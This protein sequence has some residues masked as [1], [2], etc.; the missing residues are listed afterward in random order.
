MGTENQISALAELG[1]V[2]PDRVGVAHA[3]GCAHQAGAA[4]RAWRQVVSA[5]FS[6]QAL[7][8]GWMLCGK[9]LTVAQLQSLQQDLHQWAARIEEAQGLA[10]LLAQRLS[11]ELPPPPD[12]KG[13]REQM[14]ERGLNPVTWRWLRQQN[15]RVTER[16]FAFGV[17]PESVWWANVLCAARRTGEP[18][19]LPWLENGRLRYGAALYRFYQ[20]NPGH[21]PWIQTG[22]ERLV[23]VLPEPTAQH[24]LEWEMLVHHISRKLGTV[25]GEAWIA[26]NVTWRSIHRQAVAEE[27]ERRNAALS[28]LP[29][30]AETDATWPALTGE[31]QLQGVQLKELTCERELVEEGVLMSHCVGNGTYVHDC[32]KGTQAIFRLQEPVLGSLATLQVRRDDH[33]WRIGQLSGPGNTPVPQLFWQ[34]AQALL[35]RLQGAPQASFE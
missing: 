29:A 11:F 25:Q 2:W 21:Q 15:A 32:L 27:L 17:S 34:A 7:K 5:V 31:V 1:W 18:L 35:L 13:L 28:K 4:R 10:P 3:V 22:V 8:L 24:L 33:R 26:R 30:P 9:Q 6:N 16:L 14:L 12:L 20:A 23:R 19:A